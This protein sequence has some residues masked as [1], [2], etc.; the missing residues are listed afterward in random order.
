MYVCVSGVGGWWV[1]I[2]GNDTI[3]YIKQ[4]NKNVYA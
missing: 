1:V 4:I 3:I 2:C